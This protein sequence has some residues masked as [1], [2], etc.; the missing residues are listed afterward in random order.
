[1]KFSRP[2]R[3]N[4]KLSQISQIFFYCKY[5]TEVYSA[6]FRPI[7]SLFR[8]FSTPSLSWKNLRD[9]NLDRGSKSARFVANLN[10]RN[11]RN[12]R[13]FYNSTIQVEKNPKLSHFLKKN[14]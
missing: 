9:K 7:R 14:S 12:L 1:M 4:Y 8:R 5:Q 3:L 11:L 2:V 13:E 6:D 10:L